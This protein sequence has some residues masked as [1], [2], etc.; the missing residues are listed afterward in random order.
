MTRDCSAPP[1]VRIMPLRLS[2]RTPN[3]TIDA[4]VQLKQISHM[5]A[6]LLQIFPSWM[7]ACSCFDLICTVVARAHYPACVLFF[8][9][10][11]VG[12]EVDILV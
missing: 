4:L 6:G 11:A 3:A 9:G 7:P 1:R 8:F 12:A 2:V 10:M 5:Y